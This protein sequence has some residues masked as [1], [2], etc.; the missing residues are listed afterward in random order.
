[1]PKAVGSLEEGGGEGGGG[2][3]YQSEVQRPLCFFPLSHSENPAPPVAL[4]GG[5]GRDGGS[6]AITW[7]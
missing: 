3:L 4:A 2:R 6:P 1:M 5:V 7:F